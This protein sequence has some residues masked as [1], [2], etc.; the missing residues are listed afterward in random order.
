[1][2]NGLVSLIAL[3]FL[4]SFIWMV[5]V[6]IC[7]SRR[8]KKLPPYWSLCLFSMFIELV[9]IYFLLL[10]AQLV[11]ES[12]ISIFVVPV[13]SAGVAGWFYLYVAGLRDAKN[14]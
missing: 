6:A 2:T 9:L 12:N 1:M 3:V 13:F 11:S 10:V 8:R 5:P 4:Y 7:G 14:S